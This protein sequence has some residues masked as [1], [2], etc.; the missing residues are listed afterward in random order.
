MIQRQKEVSCIIKLPKDKETIL[1]S[2]PGSR[3]LTIILVLCLGLSICTVTGQVVEIRE[4]FIGS[5]D[6][7][8]RTNY[9][10]SRDH[11]QAWGSDLAYG[12][13][14]KTTAIGCSSFYG[15]NFTG[16]GSFL[17]TSPEHYLKIS[18]A[19]FLNATASISHSMSSIEAKDNL[20]M[21]GSGLSFTMFSAE[22]E[23]KL[24]ELVLT[25]GPKGRSVDLVSTHHRGLF[26][27]NSST[28]FEI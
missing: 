26:R 15:F 3:L 22:G 16:E 12:R 27:I 2:Y 18:Q 8:T 24:R 13:V 7:D 1:V 5:G 17:A 11:S 6:F 19:S 9:P 4:D 28:R 21:L 23:G 14:L 25:F 20:T 10:E